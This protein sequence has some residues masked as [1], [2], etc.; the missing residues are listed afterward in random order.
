MDTEIIVKV[1]ADSQL[2]LPPEIQAKLRP[3]DKYKASVAED[4]IVFKKVQKPLTW[5]E[6]SQQIEELGSD[7]NQPTLQEISEIVK[8][9]RQ[10]Q[11][12]KG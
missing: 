10:E 6:L 8:E 9:V 12:P 5:T 2:E 11:Q 7:P 1:T 4:S 3:G